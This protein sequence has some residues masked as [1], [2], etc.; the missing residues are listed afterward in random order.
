MQINNRI[1]QLG[2][3][4]GNYKLVCLGKRET[5]QTPNIIKQELIGYSIFEWDWGN[6]YRI[7]SFLNIHGNNFLN[8]NHDDIEKAKIKANNMPIWPNEGSIQ[9]MDNIIVVKLSNY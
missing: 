5:I 1:E 2:Y 7:R 4:N 6:P 3:S 8:I 9:L